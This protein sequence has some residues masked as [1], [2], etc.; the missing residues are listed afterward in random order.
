MIV[1]LKK[2]VIKLGLEGIEKKKREAMSK[3][4]EILHMIFLTPKKTLLPTIEIKKEIPDS[5]FNTK[6]EKVFYQNNLWPRKRKKHQYLFLAK[7]AYYHKKYIDIGVL[8]IHKRSKFG[9]YLK[10]NLIKDENNYSLK[11]KNHP[12]GYLKFPLYGRDKKDLLETSKKYHFDKIL[13]ITW[14]CWF[15]KNGKPCGKCPMCRERII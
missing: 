3:T 1:S 11:N 13:K 6:F 2:A 9:L 7:F 15:P 12:L 14:S 8:G 5:N 10:Y 4:I